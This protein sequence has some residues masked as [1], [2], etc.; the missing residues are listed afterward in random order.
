MFKSMS[1]LEQKL[2]FYL[3][4]KDQRVFTIK[5]IA[6]ILNISY[7][8]ARNVASDMVKK[9]AAE[10]VKPGLYVRIPES[11]I[12][13]KQ[14]YTEDAILIAAKSTKKSF[15][16]HYTALTLHGI[17]ERYTTQLYVTTIRH[18]RDITYHEIQIHFIKTIPNRFFGK[19]ITTY[20]N[21]KIHVSTIERTILEIISKPRYAGGWSETIHCLKNI[22]EINWNKLLTYIKK[23][24]NKTLARKTGYI[25]DNLSNLSL[26]QSIKKEIQNFSGTNIYYFDTTKK[27]IYDPNWN[28]IIPKEVKEV[29]HAY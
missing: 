5:D 18:Q 22:E 24:N 23:F 19:T 28:I 1:G 21:E 25:L 4:E 7:A 11:V 6:Q 2:Y 13:D 17:A 16:S 10:R 15:F 8:H 9:N 12:L 14:Q 26:P 27:G 29:I 20:S 3:G